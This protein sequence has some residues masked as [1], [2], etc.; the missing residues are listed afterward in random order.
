MELKLNIYNDKGI[1]KTYV[2]QDFRPIHYNVLHNG[3]ETAT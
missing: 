3:Y 1:E 2:V